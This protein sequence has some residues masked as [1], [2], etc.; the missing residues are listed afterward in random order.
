[1]KILYHITNLPPRLPNTEASL[2][3]LNALISH[4]GGKLIYLNPNT[5]SPI[6]L[7]RLLFGFHELKQIHRE[8]DSYAA[9]HVYNAD[10]FPFPMVRWLRKPVIYSVI[11]GVAN[12]RPNVGFFNSLA[13]VTVS[14]ERSLK[15]LQGWG[16]KNAYRVLPGINSTQF[17]YSPLPL[18]SEFRLMV[19]SAPWLP[20][21]F[22]TKGFEAL[23]GA[24]KQN[25][26]LRLICLWRGVLYEEMKRRVR[27][28]DLE[29]QVETINQAVDV[30]QILAGV[31]AC[32][33][34]ATNP[35]IIRSYPHSL[36]ESLAAGKPVI[37]SDAIPMADYVR[38][39]QCGTVVKEVTPAGILQALAELI[40]EYPHYQRAALQVGQRDFQQQA[41]VES[42][43]QV[44]DSVL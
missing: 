30:N 27:E 41:L 12:R 20:G 33:N 21:Q 32:I 14:D 3:E 43:K 25:P 19:G 9:H 44:Y 5:R 36:M 24:V 1:M 39:N 16:I 26:Q 2:Q 8:E 15:R 42:F 6:Y 29:T 22:R 23:L 7:P 4:F 38:Q 18:E 31:H 28:L 37:V 17:S 35:A 13:A 10:L 11:S 34:L 40:R